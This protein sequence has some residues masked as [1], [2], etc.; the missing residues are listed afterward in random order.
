MGCHEANSTLDGLCAYA[1]HRGPLRE[2]IHQLKYQDLRD[3]AA[4]LGKLMSD[5]WAA[6]SPHD[7]EIDVIVPV[8]LHASRQ[9]ERGYNQAAL[10]ALELGAHLQLPVVQNA[11][12]RTRATAPQV[13]LN[14]RERRINVRDAFQC[15][16][17]SLSGRRVLLVDDVYT[18]GST[19]EAAA[20]AL[21]KGDVPFVWAYTLAR[22]S[23]KQGPDADKYK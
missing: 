11:L 7:I 18:T 20:K 21:R 8:P 1:F 13:E 10:L 9:Q 19:L 6:L 14:A 16:N 23:E 2:A 5:G 22:A 15:V 4:P 17:H 3:L 12:V